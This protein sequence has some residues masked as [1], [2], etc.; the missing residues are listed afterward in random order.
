MIRLKVRE[1][2]QIK[3]MS[4]AK[5][6]RKADIS[7]NTIQAICNNPQHDVSITVLHRIAQALGVSVC[8]LIEETKEEI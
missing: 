7:Y 6:S 5:L 2:I 3:N 8:D 1:M 4:M